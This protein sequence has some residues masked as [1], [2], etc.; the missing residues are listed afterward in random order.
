[1][2]QCSTR[3]LPSGLTPLPAGP[4][5]PLLQELP[6]NKRKYTTM[7]PHKMKHSRIRS[8]SVALHSE[9][10]DSELNDVW[11]PGPASG[12]LPA[13]HRRAILA[14]EHLVRCGAAEFAHIR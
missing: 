9:C 14:L 11:L 5:S 10:T 7:I 4:K 1:M 2:I 12:D 6:R 3:I 13:K 8:I